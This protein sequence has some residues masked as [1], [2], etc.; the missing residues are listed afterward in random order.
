MFDQNCAIWYIIS[1][2]FS[3]GI[4]PTSSMRIVYM[5]ENDMAKYL[6]KKNVLTFLLLLSFVILIVLIMANKIKEN[7]N[8]PVSEATEAPL[9]TVQA[10][11]DK[12]SLLALGYDYDAAI[13]ILNGITD[14]ERKEEISAL[15]SDYESKKASCVAYP[16]DQITHVFFHTLLSDYEK[17]FDGDFDSVGYNQVMTT[18]D[19]FN[20]IMQQMYDKGWVLV[21][22]H[23]I[24]G[25]V[26]DENGNQVWK[27]KT[28]MLPPGK[29]AF[30]LS[31]D[32]V[33]Y[34]EYME[35]D[36]FP[37]NLC[38]AEDGSVTN[39]LINDDGTIVYGSYD[40]VPLLED[41][42]KEHPD[43]SYKGA[44]GLLA[45]TGYNGI[46]GYRT[47]DEYKES[48]GEE[49][50]NQ[51]IEDA[52]KVAARL[53][54][55]GWGF[56][57]HT[58]GHVNMGEASYERVV[59]DSDKWED[60]V[61]TIIGEC[62]VLI[63]PFGSDI[64]NWKPY[65]TQDSKFQYLY[66]CGFRYFCNVDSNTAWVQN[67]DGYLRQGRRNLD[68]YRMYYDMIDDEVDKLSDLFDVNTVF[69]SHRPVPVP[70]M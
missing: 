62:D 3:C 64:G 21:D 65:D 34:Y 43:F 61:E 30:V 54:E 37:K 67:N 63:Y 23:D 48:L 31:Q 39:S 20:K 60:R 24:A 53:K 32:D 2:G 5:K 68:G 40:V 58:W 11:I 44:R 56:A 50:W 15:I 51:E 7:K 4:C 28:I 46:L 13:D 69:D 17:G 41:F 55:L 29:K 19:E 26:T 57:S 47:D 1:C 52:K 42:I 36:G 18:V 8:E 59:T 12:A 10:D 6:N 70:E 38:I 9:D 45:L 33:C 49:K 25:Y 22:I 35:D 16:I 27:E 14:K 66:Q